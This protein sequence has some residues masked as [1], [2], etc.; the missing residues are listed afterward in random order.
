MADWK[1]YAILVHALKSSSKTIGAME[2]SEVAYTEEMAAK[3]A[4]EATIRRHHD[5]MMEEYRRILGLLHANPQI[6]E[7]EADAP[8][9]AM[10]EDEED[11]PARLTSLDITEWRKIS[12][13]VRNLLETFEA[14]AVEDYVG[15]LADR[16]YKGKAL[17]DLLGPIMDK[18]A[19]FDFPGAIEELESVE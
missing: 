1:N 11:Q 14:D 5:Q 12:A 19:Q 15:A 2:L 6:F 10:H 3:E 8:A 7:P 16:S 17:P 9:E 4:D 18:V 13:D